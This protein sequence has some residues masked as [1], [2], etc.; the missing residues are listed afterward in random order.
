MVDFMRWYHSMFETL[1][2]HEINSMQINAKKEGLNTL[3]G[4]SILKDIKKLQCDTQNIQRSI[5]G[6][7]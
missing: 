6:G 2:E 3:E 7:D 4:N 1:I 5:N